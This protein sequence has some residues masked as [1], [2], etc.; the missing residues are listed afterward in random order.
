RV[1]QFDLAR[2]ERLVPESIY[3]PFGLGGPGR[4]GGM[5]NLDFRR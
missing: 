3:E 1:A 5:R 4:S 2:G